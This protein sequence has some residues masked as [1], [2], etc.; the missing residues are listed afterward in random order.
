[1]P[2]EPRDEDSLVALLVGVDDP[3]ACLADPVPKIGALGG[4][5]RKRQAEREQENGEAGGDSVLN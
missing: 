5:G 3:A 1:V 2:R 4:P